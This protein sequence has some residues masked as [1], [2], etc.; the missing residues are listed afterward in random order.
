VSIESLPEG[1]LRVVLTLP[2]HRAANRG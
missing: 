1:G 2:T